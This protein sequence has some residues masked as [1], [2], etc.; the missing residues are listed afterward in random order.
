MKALAKLGV[1]LTML[2]VCACERED[3]PFSRISPDRSDTRQD[4][5]GYVRATGKLHVTRNAFSV[6][7][8]Q[9]LFDWF[10]CSGCHGGR[11]GG[12]IGPALTDAEWRYGASV[13]EVHR[14]IA[15]GRPNG[16][17]AFAALITDDE[18]WQLSAYVLSLSGRVPQDVGAGRPE[19]IS[20]GEPPAMHTPEPPKPEKVN[21]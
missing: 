8:G 10:N 19:G 1:V 13:E 11:G 4:S 18:I 9:R 3:R 15:A 2:L 6:S 21:R 5:A 17:P 12:H 16:M 7:E 20:V 14:S